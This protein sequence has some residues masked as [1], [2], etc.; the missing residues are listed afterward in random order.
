MTIRGA[1][2]LASA[3]LVLPAQEPAFGF[4][5]W[6]L[7]H[8]KQGSRWPGTFASAQA[9]QAHQGAADASADDEADSNLHASLS[10]EGIQNVRGEGDC[11]CSRQ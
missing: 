4:S 5:I 8:C 2:L 11:A 10:F 6:G 1:I 9:Q 3:L 7:S